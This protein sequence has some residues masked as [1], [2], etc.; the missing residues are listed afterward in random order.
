MSHT[1]AAT[2]IKTNPY[3][4]PPKAQVL[5][6]LQLYFS[7]CHKL[8]PYIDE[9]TFYEEYNH[10]ELSGFQ[11][12]RRSWLAL[13]NILFA[14]ALQ[15]DGAGVEEEDRVRKADIFYRRAKVLHQ[16]TQ[17][18]SLESSMPYII[19]SD[20]SANVTVDVPVPSKYPECE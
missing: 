10:A 3:T 7:R 1:P 13:L 11:Q 4:L 15:L 5:Q 20:C 17:V 18:Y 14:M 9:R 12:I 16:D 2:A 8:F 6:Y 19:F